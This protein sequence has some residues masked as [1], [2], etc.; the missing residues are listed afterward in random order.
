MDWSS[1]GRNLRQ[2]RQESG[3]RQEDLA[4]AA[5]LS[6]NYIGMVERGEKIPSLETFVALLNLL[7]VS[8]DMVLTDVVDTGYTVKQSMLAEQVGR[9]PAAERER[10]YAVVQVLV[11]RADTGE[12]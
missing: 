10:I 6:V 4:R 5:G 11:D 9:L 8:A 1:I 3:L 2:Y 7:H 12:A